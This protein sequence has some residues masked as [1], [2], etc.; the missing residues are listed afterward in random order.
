MKRI[1][2]LIGLIAAIAAPAASGAANPYMHS[3]TQVACTTYV[4]PNHTIARRTI[5]VS[6]PT[7]TSPYLPTMNVSW[8]P[9]LYRYYDG[10]GWSVIAQGPQLWGSTA[11]GQMPAQE[12]SGWT[13]A[14]GNVWYHVNVVYRW[15]WNGSV[16]HTETDNT[17]THVNW[18]TAM[19]FDGRIGYGAMGPVGSSCLMDA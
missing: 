2:T 17:S 3:A 8:Q 4:Y 18:A 1:V 13:V 16:Y 15:Y 10:Y 11:F 9:V 5:T 19:N 14:D 6:R 12:F 7:L